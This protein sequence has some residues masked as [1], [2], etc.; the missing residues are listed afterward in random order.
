MSSRTV[1]GVLGAVVLTGAMWIG[2]RPIGR[3]PPLGALLDPARGV[4]A[5]ATHA[6]H[7]REATISIPSLT[8]SV[9]VRYDDRGVPHIFAANELDAVRAL[10][11]VVARDRLFQLELQTRAAAG[12]LT[13]LVGARALGVDRDARR[14][15]LPWG[16]KRK[17]AGTDTTTL[18]RRTLDAYAEGVNAYIDGMSGA[19][20]PLEYRL[21]NA[22]PQRWQPEHSM[23]LLVRMGYTLAW[24]DFEVKRARVEARIGRAATDALFPRDAYIVEPIQPNGRHG[25]ARAAGA[26]PTPKPDSAAAEL[27]RVLASIPDVTDGRQASNNWAVAPLRSA[28]GHALLANDPH[29]DLSLP[30]VWYE[31]HIVVRDSLDV[32]GVTF[33]GAPSIVLGLN[34]DVAWGATNVGADVADYYVETVDDSTSPMRYRVD[35]QWRDLVR[36]VEPY[37]D[38]AGRTVATDTL[39]YTHRGP[40]NRVGARWISRRWMVLEP[41]AD[42]DVFRAATRS[43]SVAEFFS[44]MNGFDSPAQNFIV[45]DRVGH[46]GIRS[47]GRYP[48]RPGDGRGDRLFDGS[49][50]ASDWKGWITPLNAPQAIDPAQGF[51]VS[52]NQQPVDPR[53]FPAYL[54]ADWVS[55]WR[56]MRINSL[57]SADRAMTADKMR[58]MQSDPGSARADAFVPLFM[59]AAENAIRAGRGDSTLSQAAKL[60]GEWDRRYT[61][62]NQRA[63]LFEAA[64]DEL[65]RLTWDEL[66]PDSGRRVATPW[67]QVLLALTREPNSV[68]WDRRATTARE[69]RDA[70]LTTALAGALDSTIR[71]RGPAYDGGWRWSAVRHANIW[72]ALRLPALSAIDIPVQSGPETISPSFG[73]GTHG[74]SWRLV[75]DMGPEIRAWGIYPGGQSANP[76]SA[77]YRDRIET[78]R[79]GELDSL[80][81][82]ASPSQLSE[83]HTAATLTL[84]PS[85]R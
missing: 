22:Q 58:A 7:P 74:A 15:G 36:S 34:R 59:S 19:D 68:W 78:W 39:Y 73:S 10:G 8:S 61:P 83:R 85:G 71:A 42:L 40:L 84:A 67:D 52:A 57:L 64:M 28:N 80:R 81:I 12:T 9:D 4:W 14:I 38:P 6:T 72:H 54:G 37:R 17:F 48:L 43:R 79:R 56:A 53:A 62:D 16:A 31:A 24:S 55:P 51:V 13:E 44:A 20:L 5:L 66:A 41:S 70:I 23:L 76:V 26:F 33:P 50:S 1:S 30:S 11:Y 69:T 49:T 29:L 77:H 63:V 46:I 3:V 2:A 18:A 60:L 47:T 65:V 75:T 45:S 32:Y 21:L 27:A 25:E 35:G 82:P